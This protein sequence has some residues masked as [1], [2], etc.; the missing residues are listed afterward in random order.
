MLFTGWLGAGSEHSSGSSALSRSLIR[1][2]LQLVPLK[3]YM[4]QI[5]RL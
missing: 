4:V 1:R 5:D 3:T 2:R